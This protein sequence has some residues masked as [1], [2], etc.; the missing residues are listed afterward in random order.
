MKH[1]SR[2]DPRAIGVM[3]AQTR[4]GLH[5]INFELNKRYAS[6]ADMP[7]EIQKLVAR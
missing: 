6:L 3:I 7:P 2:P 1:S 4:D 5:E